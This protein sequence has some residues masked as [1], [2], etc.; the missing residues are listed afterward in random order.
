MSFLHLSPPAHLLS[1]C[2]CSLVCSR[3]YH[4][5]CT[6]AGAIQPQNT[7]TWK[8]RTLQR[9]QQTFTKHLLTANIW[10]TVDGA[11]GFCSC[12]YF[13]FAPRA[14][15]AEHLPRQK[16]HLPRTSEQ[17]L[18][19]SPEPPTGRWELS[20]LT[21]GNY[22]RVSSVVMKHFYLQHQFW[23]QDKTFYTKQDSN[24]TKLKI[25]WATHQ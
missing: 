1:S 22:K 4:T 16:D 24:T 25:S 6:K 15:R 7:N 18:M 12:L 9:E 20:K 19:S 2:M 11:C 8:I 23:Y 13:S 21:A 17:P 5:R 10:L 14:T 3:C